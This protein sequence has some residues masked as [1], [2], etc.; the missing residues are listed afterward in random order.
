V[1]TG[2]VHFKY[3]MRGYLIAIPV[4][5][6]TAMYNF[7]GGLGYLV[8]YTLGRWCDGDWDLVT[9][10]NSESRLIKELPVLGNILFGIASIYG[11]FFFHHH[12]APITHWPVVSTLIRLIF[13]FI[14]PF[15]VGDGYGIN[16]IG[17]GWIWFWVNLWLGLSHADAIHLYYDIFPKEE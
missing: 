13:I 9:A 7:R 3:Y 4:S 6:A 12:R 17:N 8:G 14:I 2:V 11:S 16:F 5:V 10:N 15:I 1:S